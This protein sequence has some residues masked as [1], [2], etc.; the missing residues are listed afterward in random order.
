MLKF[1]FIIGLML[2]VAFFYVP[3]GYPPCGGPF[4]PFN[5]CPN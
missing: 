4:D 1:T 3:V 2:S 5:T